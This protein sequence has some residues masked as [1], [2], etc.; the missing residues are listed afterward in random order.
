[1]NQIIFTG[2]VAQWASIYLVWDENNWCGVGQVSPTPFGRLSS[3]SVVN[4]EAAEIDHRG[5]D[6]GSPRWVRIQ[7]GAN[8]IRFFYSITGIEWTELR[9]I[10]R[11]KRFTASP[12]LIA[13][14]KYYEA[15]DKPFASNA[16]STEF[17]QQDGRV[18]GR[19]SHL[20]IESLPSS[21]SMLSKAELTLLRKPKVDPVTAILS[22]SEEDPTFEKI[23]NFYPPMKA[24]R[25]VVG[26]PAHPLDIGV[27]RLGRLD[28][29]PWTQPVA[30]FEIG[31]PLVPL[32]REDVPFTRRLL[33]GYLPID[34][35]TTMRDGI[36]YSL[37]VFGWSEGLSVDKPLHAYIRITAKSLNGAA[38]PKQIALVSPGNKRKTWSLSPNQGTTSLY[39]KFKYPEPDSATEIPAT[40]FDSRQNEVASHWKTRLAP[41][42]RFDIPDARVMEAYRA[43][44]VYSMLNA[45]T[46]NGYIE[47]HDGAGF[48][49]EMFGNSVSLQSIATDMY[50]LHD[51][52]SKI[53]DTQIHFQQ[54]KGLYTQV[55]GLTDP[56]GF[57]VGLARHYRMTGDREWLQHV[58]PNIIAQCE[59]LM[60]QRA[61]A[62]T[63]G[64]VPRLV[65]FRPYNDYS[66]EV[67]NYLGNAWCAQGLADA[68]DALQVL[69]NPDASKYAVEAKNI[70]RI[71]WPQWKLQRSNTVARHCCLWSQIHT[72]Y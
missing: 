42:E 14:G 11:P 21:N 45:D 23:V 48:Y 16:K 8:Y 38:L 54:T 71:Y 40:E 34:T 56:G 55:C 36:E 50:G 30:W 28:V 39:L 35:L 63:Q 7:L 68:A 29:S 66:G 12:R 32:G 2:K 57:L 25:E 64:V 44:I 4:G 15:E 37:T 65:K 24:P 3:T 59:W 22:Q 53:L 13:A 70:A 17:R 67:Y 60:L 1:M 19:V 58:S 20:R 26:V 47:P 61:K 9:T 43:W 5:I 6:F 52:A 49:E 46:I 31:D 10:E 51:Y 33:N 72:A 69:G 27:D 62:P 41:A 18:S